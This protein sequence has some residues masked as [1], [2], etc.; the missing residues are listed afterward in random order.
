MTLALSGAA[1]LAS[2]AEAHG[3]GLNHCGCHFNRKT[4]ECHCHR[5][6]DCGCEC[7]PRAVRDER[8]DVL[9]SAAPSTRHF[10]SERASKVRWWRSLRSPKAA[11]ARSALSG[12]AASVQH[13]QETTCGV[14]PYQ[15]S[16]PEVPDCPKAT[17]ACARSI[18]DR[19]LVSISHANLRL[20]GARD[21]ENGRRGPG[22]NSSS[23]RDVQH[24]TGRT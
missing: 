17:I 12:C 24:T 23:P 10:S 2:Y 9:A 21:V 7:Q 19:R 1:W 20:S 3:G 4:S 18:R 6:R 8:R 16:A 13:D 15:P 22:H 14:A 11:A 5:D